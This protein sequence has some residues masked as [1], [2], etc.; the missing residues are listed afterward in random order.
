MS[1]SDFVAAGGEVVGVVVAA[2]ADWNGS[3]PETAGG[4]NVSKLP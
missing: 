2:A 1:S 4:K 3:E